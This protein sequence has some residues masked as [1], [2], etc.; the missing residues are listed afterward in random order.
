MPAAPK[1]DEMFAAYMGSGVYKSYQEEAF[2]FG[3][4]AKL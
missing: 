1:L 4:P 2:N 3:E